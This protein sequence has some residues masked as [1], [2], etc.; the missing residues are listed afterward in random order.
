MREEGGG[1][2]G[3]EKQQGMNVTV[4]DLPPPRPRCPVA[5]RVEGPEWRGR[6][7]AERLLLEEMS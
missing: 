4:G 7:G 3:L 6:A 1:G 2:R 5:T